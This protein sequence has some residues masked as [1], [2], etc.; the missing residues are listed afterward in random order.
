MRI[1]IV[2]RYL[3]RVSALVSWAK[4]E[5]Q[6]LRGRRLDRRNIRIPWTWKS[7]RKAYV[8]DTG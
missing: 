4:H 5:G 3:R 2:A 6:R 1:A 7:A 8:V